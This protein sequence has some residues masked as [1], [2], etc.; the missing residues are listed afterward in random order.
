M[1]ESGFIIAMGLCLWFAKMSWRNRVRLLSYPLSIDIAVFIGVTILH[2]GTYTGVM[3]AA[4][5]SLMIS[6]LITGARKLWGY[7]DNGKYVR[8]MF[9]MSHRV[10]GI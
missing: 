5:A 3:S 1:L 6:I 10:Q 9:D 4:V 2:W 7:N 8:G